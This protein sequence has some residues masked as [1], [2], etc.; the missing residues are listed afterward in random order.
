MLQ[1][2]KEAATTIELLTTLTKLISQS[3]IS[4][5]FELTIRAKQ[6]IKLSIASMLP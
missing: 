5:V 1:L 3:F 4:E 6:L 2:I